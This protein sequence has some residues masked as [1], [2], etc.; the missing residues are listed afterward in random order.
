MVIGPTKKV[1]AY[2]DEWLESHVK[3]TV[4]ATTYDTY[5]VDVERLRP[6]ATSGWM[7]SGMSTSSMHIPSY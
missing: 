3:L 6:S 5:K 2:L 4:Q 7:P 1:G